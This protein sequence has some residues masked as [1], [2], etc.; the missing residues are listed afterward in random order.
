M[1]NTLTNTWSMVLAALAVLSGG[2]LSSCGAELT[3]PLATAPKVEMEPTGAPSPGAVNTSVATPVVAES[4]GVLTGA[5]SPRNVNTRPAMP[6]FDAF[7]IITHKNAAP[8]SYIVQFK[9]AMVAKGQ[10]PI[11]KMDLAKNIAAMVVKENQLKTVKM[12]HV[13]NAAIRGFSAKMTQAEAAILAKT[14]VSCWWSRTPMSMPTLYIRTP[15]GRWTGLT[16]PARR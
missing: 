8:D 15:A 16:K 3:Q 10:N 7:G 2:L 4:E 6:A 13:F 1:K 5:T 9:D 14:P 12:S 11:L